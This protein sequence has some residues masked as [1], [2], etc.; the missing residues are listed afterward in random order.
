MYHTVI[1]K[2]VGEKLLRLLQGCNLQNERFILLTNGETYQSDSVVVKNN[3]TY[4]LY[5]KSG[6]IG[7]GLAII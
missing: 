4:L 3:I 2:E 7:W 1:K 5:I 6:E